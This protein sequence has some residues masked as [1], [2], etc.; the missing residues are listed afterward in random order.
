MTRLILSLCL[1]LF[2]S[3]TFAQKQKIEYDKN[4]RIISVDGVSLALMEKEGA[5]GQLGIN[6]NFT[7]TNLEGKELIFMAFTQ[8][9]EYQNGYKTGKTLTYYVI[10]FVESGKTSKKQGT[11]KSS[12]AAKLIAKNKLIVDGQIDPRAEEK[13]HLKY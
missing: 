11:L 10:E 8:R 13:F 1:V 6:S 2:A 7:I 4:T 12:G 9:P 5:P 3:S